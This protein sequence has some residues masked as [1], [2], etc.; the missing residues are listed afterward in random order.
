MAAVWNFRAQTRA[1]G[2]LRS[3]Q[4]FQAGGHCRGWQ[5]IPAALHPRRK[6]LPLLWESWLGHQPAPSLYDADTSNRQIIPAC[7]REGCFLASFTQ[8]HKSH[9]SKLP[10]VVPGDEGVSSVSSLRR[11]IL[12]T[13][14]CPLRDDIKNFQTVS[15]LLNNPPLPKCGE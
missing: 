13:A 1:E 8:L 3:W 6:G 7:G 10:V 11:N 9:R 12:T 4:T 15:A 2:L 14:S 5:G